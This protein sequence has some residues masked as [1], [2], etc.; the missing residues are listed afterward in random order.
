[1]TGPA[2][3]RQ[4][5]LKAQ[6]I[7]TYFKVDAG[8][9]AEGSSLYSTSSGAQTN[10]SQAVAANFG[11]EIGLLFTSPI[12][13][14][15]LGIEIL[16]PVK[17]GGASG[18][19]ASGSQLM[20]VDSSILGWGPSFHLENYFGVSSVQRFFLSLGASYLSMTT[21]NAYQLTPAG[22]AAY[23]GIA[24]YT[25]TGTASGM[26]Y[27]ASLA[28]EFGFSDWATMCIEGGYRYVV[29]GAL[30][31]KSDVAGFTGNQTA[32]SA[33][34]NQNGSP[35]TLNLT[36]PFAGIGFRFYFKN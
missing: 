28:W 3:A 26:D 23:P 11:G 1:M 29:L 4:F 34:V 7:A 22:Q 30:T 24:N 8:T 35:R 25:E 12:F 14:A 9:A 33:L 20:T 5:D 17:V 19:N 6:K 15:R 16:N 13:G 32:G 21:T 36:G 27:T 2:W 10:F 18:T 31:E